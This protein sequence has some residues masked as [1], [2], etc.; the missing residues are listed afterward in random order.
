MNSLMHFRPSGVAARP[1]SIIITGAP[2]GM[3]VYGTQGAYRFPAVY[4]P[5]DTDGPARYEIDT[6][7]VTSDNGQPVRVDLSAYSADGATLRYTSAMAI[8]GRVVPVA[9]GEF[10]SGNGDPSADYR[11]I[12]Y[13]VGGAAIVGLAAWYFW[14]RRR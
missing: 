1:P 11:H 4:I 12:A 9:W 6:S 2:V 5:A 14:P 8:P 7:T 13:G 3:T 10:L